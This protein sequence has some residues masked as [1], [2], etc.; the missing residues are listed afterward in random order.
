MTIQ[1]GTLN[2]HPILEDSSAT[3]IP[4]TDIYSNGTDDLVAANAAVLSKSG[5]T[6][7]FNAAPGVN[8]DG[9]NT[10]GLGRFSVPSFWVDTVTDNAYVCVDNASGA[11]VWKDMNTGTAGEIT[12]AVISTDV[13]GISTV[14]QVQYDAL[15]PPTS[16]IL[17]IITG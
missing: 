7:T 8:D 11:A 15:N 4:I 5:L 14:T 6:T 10:G 3:G 16:G 12:N 1:K 17:Y 9:F 2:N 13:T